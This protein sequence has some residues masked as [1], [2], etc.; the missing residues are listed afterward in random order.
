[1]SGDLHLLEIVARALTEGSAMYRVG[2]DLAKPGSD[3]TIA[4]VSTPYREGDSMDKYLVD[5]LTVTNRTYDNAIKPGNPIF[6]GHL[7]A[8]DGAAINAAMLEDVRRLTGLS[9]MMTCN[10]DHEAELKYERE[11]HRKTTELLIQRDQQ[12]Q[13]QQL[14]T[15][16][17]ARELQVRIL[18]RD[19][20]LIEMKRAQANGLALV[21]CTA[22]LSDVADKL[23]AIVRGLFDTTSN[24]AEYDACKEAIA[25]WEALNDPRPGEAGDGPVGDAP[26]RHV[27]DC[28]GERP[29]GMAGG[30]LPGPAQGADDPVWRVFAGLRQQGGFKTAFEEFRSSDPAP[31]PDC[32]PAVIRAT[33]EVF[34][35][36]PRNELGALN[37][38]LCVEAAQAFAA[39]LKA[40]G[41]A[42]LWRRKPEITAKHDHMRGQTYYH[43]YCRYA[44]IPTAEAKKI[45]GITWVSRVSD[46]N[47]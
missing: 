9:D 38:R 11:A 15:E 6:E 27:A 28:Q 20:A 41:V 43:F 13:G 30:Q 45:K 25:A 35:W 29:Q 24:R 1:M 31:A 3:A 47:L 37:E 18:E 12:L 42:I 23:L 46:C 36:P 34:Q 19:V 33:F 5:S 39:R 10:V 4:I 14:V 32:D 40:Q 22:G 44:A 16:A 17:M 26:V 2:L 21:N 8:V 7:G